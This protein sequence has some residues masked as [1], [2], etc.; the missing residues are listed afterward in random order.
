MSIEL[1]LNGLTFEVPSNGDHNWGSL[2]DWIIEV[3]E[4]LNSQS[5][6]FIIPT[7]S[8][9]LIDATPVNLYTINSPQDNDHIIFEYG[10]TRYT[11]A[12]DA[13]SVSETG[14]LYLTYKATDGS[15]AYANTGVGDA[16]VAIAVSTGNVI[17]ATAT[18][19]TGTPNTSTIAYQGRI[20]RV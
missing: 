4:T 11:D 13:E 7:G 18:A 17:Q 12:P 5:T 1:E 3:N 14:T 2:S 20:I 16:R 10:I 15:W 9:N 8:A 6:G 19:L